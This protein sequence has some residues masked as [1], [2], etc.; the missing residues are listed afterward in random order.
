MASCPKISKKKDQICIGNMNKRITLLSRAITAPINGTDY[1]ETFTEIATC[2]SSIHTLKGYRDFDSVGVENSRT[3]I[4]YTHDFYIRYNSTI[5]LSAQD[6]ISY[7]DKYYRIIDIENL[8]ERGKFL[9]LHSKER[10][11]N[12]V[13]SNWV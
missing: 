2:W 12:T 6:W 11:D 5:S 1:S 4:V 8:N 13:E 10:G 3:T 9:V 7:S